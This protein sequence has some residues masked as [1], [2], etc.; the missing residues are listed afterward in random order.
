MGKI[1]SY[2]QL[3]II[4]HFISKKK[5]HRHSIFFLHFHFL[6]V[7]DEQ[8]EEKFFRSHRLLA[9]LQINNLIRNWIFFLF[10]IHIYISI[11]RRG[12]KNGTKLVC[13]FCLHFL[14]CLVK[15]RKKKNYENE[16]VKTWTQTNQLNEYADEA[17]WVLCWIQNILYI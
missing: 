9:H 15:T 17:V 10:S 7:D 16:I 1:K 6:S 3:K 4:F 5:N 14:F 11:G 13:N 8:C 2:L 12:K